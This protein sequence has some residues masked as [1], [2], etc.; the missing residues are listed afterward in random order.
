MLVIGSR[1]T[2]REGLTVGRLQ[3]K[4]AQLHRF[5]TLGSND[6]SDAVMILDS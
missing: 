1:P 4:R 6:D 5:D 3:G 2:A